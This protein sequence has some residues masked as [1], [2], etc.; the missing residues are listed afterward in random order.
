MTTSIKGEAKKN[1]KWT[2]G[3]SELWNRYKERNRKKMQK[4][5]RQTF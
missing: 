3:Q 4:R 2:N 5:D 1:M